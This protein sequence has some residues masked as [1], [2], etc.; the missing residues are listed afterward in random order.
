M[1]RSARA[2][3]DSAL[4]GRLAVGL[5]AGPA[6]QH[7][8]FALA[9]AIG[10]EERFDR[11]LVVHYREGARPVRAPEA[12]LEAP[13]IEQALER[14][15]DVGKRIAL[16]GS[17]GRRPASRAVIMMRTATAPGCFLHSAMTS[18]TAGSG[19]MSAKRP[20]CLRCTSTA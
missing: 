3:P 10:P 14:I 11:L 5:R 8:P 13:G 6:H 12:A 7:G 4:V 18:P 20:G 15:P 19:L 1:P 9:Q 2:V 17:S 16:P